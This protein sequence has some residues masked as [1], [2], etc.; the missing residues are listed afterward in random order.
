[1]LSPVESGHPDLEH[2]R[3]VAVEGGEGSVGKA[4]GSEGGERGEA[5]EGGDHEE[6]VGNEVGDA[7]ANE[8]YTEEDESMGVLQQGNCGTLTLADDSTSSIDTIGE[9]DSDGV[10]GEGS[11]KGGDV[12]GDSGL[13]GGGETGA[14]VGSL[15]GSGS[16]ALSNEFIGDLAGSVASAGGVDS[17]G[18]GDS[19]TEDGDSVGSGDSTGG[20]EPAPGG[21]VLIG[22]SQARS[23]AV[24]LDES[25][26]SGSG[27]DCND[28][29]S[30]GPKQD[31]RGK[32]DD[33]ACIL[34]ERGMVH[35][36]TS[37]C[38]ITGTDGKAIC[39]EAHSHM[40]VALSALPGIHYLQTGKACY[41]INIMK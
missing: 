34:S 16:E 1:M 6:Q 31:V 41:V 30:N 22:G 29:T 13:A 7:P 38:S 3:D 40:H 37:S 12:V 36:D 19:T 25:E 5:L 2:S 24:G 10:M 28:V 17:V 9:A 32:L 26:A 21:D 23:Q 27:A 8:R 4:E 14:W 35:S 20:H 39:T 15:S 33:N 11:V 18:S